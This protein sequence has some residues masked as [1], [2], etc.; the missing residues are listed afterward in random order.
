MS[1]AHQFET[2]LRWPALAT[3]TMPPSPTFS[4]NNIL[5]GTG[6]PGIPSRYQVLT[7]E[8][9][10]EEAPYHLDRSQLRT[11]ERL[12]LEHLE[13]NGGMTQKLACAQLNW[14]QLARRPG[15]RRTPP[16]RADRSARR[17]ARG[18]PA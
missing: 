4:R 12:F 5:G 10:E 1:D 18:H 17:D 6:K 13:K 7:D 16:V 15:H 3:Q 11:D 9:E 14:A 2:T 8:P